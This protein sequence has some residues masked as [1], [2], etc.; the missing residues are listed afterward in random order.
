VPENE[1]VREPGEELWNLISNGVQRVCD[2]CHQEL[3][4]PSFLRSSPARNDD[5]L[6][7]SSPSLL[8]IPGSPLRMSSASSDVSELGEC[9]V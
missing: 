5:I 1:L 4:L 2:S 3:Q 6:A 8:A 9:P 7:I